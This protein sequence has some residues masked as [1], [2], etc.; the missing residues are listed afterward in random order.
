M[1]NGY[2]D[3]IAK[4]L[5][6]DK[7]IIYD[8]EAG[9]AKVTGKVDVI[10]N[11]AIQ[12]DQ[13]VKDRMQR[14]G[15]PQNSRASDVYDALISKIEADDIKLFSVM[16]ISTARSAEAAQKICDFVVRVSPLQTGYFLKLE[17]AK[18]LLIAEPPRLVM[19]ALGYNT[20]ED[21]LAKEDIF[22]IYSAL[23]FLEGSDWLNNVFSKQYEK[24]RPE[25]FEIRK[26]ELRALG[27]KWAKAAQK[28]VAKKHHNVSHLKE[29]GV[30][31]VIPIFL[32]I[33]GET[34]RIFSLLLHYLREVAYY[35]ILF[36]R[37]AD[38]SRDQFSSSLI[39]L[40]RGDVIEQRSELPISAIGSPMWM[41]VQRYLAKDDENDWR[42][43]E[44][45]VNPEAMHWERAVD[46]IVGVETKIANFKD[47]LSFWQNI[48]WVG[49]Y[50][51]TE[52][53]VS[54][55]VS[56]NLID[57]VMSLVKQK[58]LSKYLYHQQE[59]LWNKIFIDYCGQQSIE[60]LMQDNA[61]QGWFEARKL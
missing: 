8:L 61:I 47:G 48:G 39:S 40:L 54:I 17:K 37:H 46:D 56:F 30:I 55:L 19:S 44:P 7:H 26:I 14:L 23:R 20:I 16:G 4:I 32:G 53:G 13:L 45:H 21:L 41:I 38:N 28:F 9:M 36:K 10:K 50:F 22:E 31:F 11:I 51:A 42:L 34:L 35:S 60:K 12:N 43:L 5:R 3:K 49:D 6:V 2:H 33:S 52:T 15:L 25:D 27:D 18:E 59:A 1:E 58:E 24:L 29:L 57:T